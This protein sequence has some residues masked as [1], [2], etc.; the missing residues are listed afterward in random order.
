MRENV[1][2]MMAA[3]VHT[4]VPLTNMR[5]TPLMLYLGAFQRKHSTKAKTKNIRNA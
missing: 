3:N 4:E 2:F 5:Y 1:L